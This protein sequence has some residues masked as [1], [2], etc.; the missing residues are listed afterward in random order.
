MSKFSN[1]VKTGFAFVVKQRLSEMKESPLFERE[2]IRHIFKYAVIEM[3]EEMSLEQAVSE[4]QMDVVE[5]FLDSSD[6]E[7]CMDDDSFPETL[8]LMRQDARLFER[9]LDVAL[10]IARFHG[11]EDMCQMLIARGAC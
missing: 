11:H 10:R 5:H 8:S 7:E 3:S 6:E 4:N 2:L 9:Q 1:S